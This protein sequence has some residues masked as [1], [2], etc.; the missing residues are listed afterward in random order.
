MCNLNKYNSNEFHKRKGIKTAGLFSLII[1][2]TLLFLCSSGRASEYQLLVEN[3]VFGVNFEESPGPLS[4]I[5]GIPKRF[6]YVL[7]SPAIESGMNIVEGDTII[8][9]LFADAN[10]ITRIDKISTN[11]NQ[12]ITMICS[13]ESHPFSDVF[14]F[15]TGSQVLISIYI[16]D[17]NKRFII[18]K[19][20][21]SGRYLL[22]EVDSSQM[23]FLDENPSNLPDSGVLL[24]ELKQDDE[25]VSAPLDEAVI[26][27]M[28]VYTPAAY[29][30]AAVYFSGME[31]YIAYL[32]NEANTVLERSQS[33]VSLNL[34]RSVLVNYVEDK[35]EVWNDPDIGLIV[36]GSL[37]VALKQLSEID[38]YM[39]EVHDWRNQYGADLVSLLVSRSTLRY[40][41]TFA[42]FANQLDKVS[43][44]PD[45]AFSVT[46]VENSNYTFIH[47]I[48]HNLGCG[49]SKYQVNYNYGGLFDYS[50]A[51][52][53]GSYC[54]VMSYPEGVYTRTGI[55]SNPDV[56][57]HNLPAGNPNEADN[58]RTIRETK[59]A[60]AAYRSH[61]DMN[62]PEHI[63]ERIF[64]NA[65]AHSGGDGHSWDSAYR[66]LRNA[67]IA[68]EAGD[69]IWVAKGIYK[70]TDG[71]N[72][73]NNR[74]KSFIL[75]NGISVYG[76]FDGIESERD[77]RNYIE[78]MTILSGEIGNPN[79]NQDN[80]RKIII[81]YGNTIL[82]GF[83]I[84]GNYGDGF[85]YSEIG[86]SGSLYFHQSENITIANSIFNNNY[87]ITGG[88]IY[89]F[90]CNSVLISNCIF[91]NNI[92][93]TGGGVYIKQSAATIRNC[94]FSHNTGN[95]SG[96]GLEIHDCNASVINCTFTSNSAFNRGSAIEVTGM[97]TVT[98]SIFWNNTFDVIDGS[99]IVNYSDL[100][101]GWHGM[102]KGNININPLFVGSG[103]WA[104]VNDSEVIV[105]QDD[106]N[107]IWIDGDY[108]LKS[109]SGRWD[110]NY[111]IWVRDYV[112]SPCVDAGNPNSDWSEELWPNGKRI[113]MGAY[114]GTAQASMST[115]AAGEIRDLNYNSFIDWNDVLLLVNEWHKSGKPMK[116]DL[117]RNGI[118]DVSDLAYYFGN[119][120]SYTD[121]IVPVLDFIADMHIDTGE[122]LIFPVS[123]FDSDNDELT[124]EALGL[125]NE[126]QFS[127]QIFSWTPKQTGTYFVTFIVS[128]YKSMDYMTVQIKVE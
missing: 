101:G 100:Q 121:N 21:G 84:T 103:Y 44:N 74:N 70:P 27:I 107:A 125:P 12:T 2:Y 39:D 118:V 13:I 48:G 15:R 31:N 96:G 63:P 32:V 25:S 36:K 52:R 43:G 95:F 104:D 19:E 53:W 41:S 97:A 58:A 47:E 26:D 109:Q 78:N 75:K 54:S 79:D 71:T 94:V 16:P 91:K 98:N 50:Y 35:A 69:E 83:T 14:I 73:K 46:A 99:P 23:P 68:A 102:G 34:V 64:V 49:H 93:D 80:S 18:R 1:V 20:I 17:F 51:W 115:S 114:G 116:G 22:I 8:L 123:A 11:I 124:Y 57:D 128:D 126:A 30:D 66:F 90:D 42:G 9:N 45:E 33:Y 62:V 60:A 5:I 40:S 67:L 28:V 59:H 122:L 56:L 110:S 55:F 120:S 77:Q 92:A 61:V 37:E 6:R 29:E 72:D 7:L 86:N 112:T 24:N 88:G 81:G 65:K 106:P 76:G 89:I 117:D 119:W 4:A 3:P 87:N 85:F 105:E 38:G 127:E 111:R 10:Y 82:D 113:N 108:H